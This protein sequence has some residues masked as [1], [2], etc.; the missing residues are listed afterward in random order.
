MATS[1]PARAS[2]RAK[3][4]PRPRLAPVTRAVFPVRSKGFITRSVSGKKSSG[5][6]NYLHVL[7]AAFAAETLKPVGALGQRSDCADHRFDPNDAARNQI[8][9]E[10]ILTGRRATAVQRDF[11]GDD[12]LEGKIDL[13]G[14][15]AHQHGGSPAAECTQRKI[16]RRAAP[17]Y[18]ERTICAAPARE[19]VDFRGNIA[20]IRSN[21]VR[22][23]EFAGEGETIFRQIDG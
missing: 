6:K 1:T 10:R 16:E 14:E 15:I 13:G 21:R 19:R 18:F 2:A 11:P 20:G 7:G 5:L 8:E 17:D 4:F 22:G 23:T 3:C 9:A 12:R